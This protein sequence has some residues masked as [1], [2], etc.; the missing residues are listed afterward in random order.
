M[1]STRKAARS[2]GPTWSADTQA[3]PL[4][5]G[6]PDESTVHFKNS[7]FFP[8]TCC[9]LSLPFVNQFCRGRRGARLSEPHL[10]QVMPH[11]ALS[12][13][14]AGQHLPPPPLLLQRPGPQ[15][16]AR[17]LCHWLAEMLGKGAGEEGQPLLCIYRYFYFCVGKGGQSLEGWELAGTMATKRPAELQREASAPGTKWPPPSREHCHRAEH[18]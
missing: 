9:S 7:Y 8:Q 6:P 13:H 15:V 3:W 17:L 12:G 1:L 14:Q 10:T 16:A 4:S 11:S 5:S 2:Q 18:W